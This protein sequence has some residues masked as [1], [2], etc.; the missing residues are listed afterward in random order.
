[1]LVR[2]R[3]LGLIELEFPSPD[4]GEL[5]ET[6]NHLMGQKPTKPCPNGLQEVPNS[7]SGE[8][9]FP[10]PKGAVGSRGKTQT[11]QVPRACDDVIGE[12][13][14]ALKIG[15][16]EIVKD[17]VSP[18]G[19]VRLEIKKGNKIWRATFFSNATQTVIVLTLP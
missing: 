2:I 19:A 1:M 16:W 12:V 8:D 14:A 17:E 9:Q 5:L 18:L 10:I 11:Y 7:T 15:G 6:F 13:R 4:E 3:P